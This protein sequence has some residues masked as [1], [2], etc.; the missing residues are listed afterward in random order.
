MNSS[1]FCRYSNWPWFE[2]GRKCQTD[3]QDHVGI[4]S[5]CF[6]GGTAGRQRGFL[7]CMRSLQLNGLALDLEERA[8][9]TPGV[10]PGCPG[11]C[12]SY[13]HLCRNGGRC[14]EKHR[15]I[16][17]DCTFS[18]YDGPFCENGEWDREQDTEEV[19]DS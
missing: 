17:C 6:V 16:T 10:E 12:S 8:T 19:W 5:V 9:M 14:R 3:T 4:C 15:G 7:G 11:H 2:V 1:L 13:G 18:A